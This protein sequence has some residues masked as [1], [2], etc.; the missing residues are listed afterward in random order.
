[1]FEDGELTISLPNGRFME[2]RFDFFNNSYNPLIFIR[3][4]DEKA[5]SR[6]KVVV[7]DR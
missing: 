4:L 3:P 7:T 2:C 1:M 5:H 6:V